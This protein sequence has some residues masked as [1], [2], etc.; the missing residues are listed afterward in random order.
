M[1]ANSFDIVPPGKLARVLPTNLPG[2]RSGLFWLRNKA[3]AQV[4]LTDW[5]R[6][7]VLPRRDGGMVLLSPQRPDALLAALREAASGDSSRAAG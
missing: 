7:L 6:V 3:R 4:L 1:I 2:Y 5:R